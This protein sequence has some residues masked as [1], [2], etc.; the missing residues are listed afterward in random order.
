MRDLETI[1][2]AI[3]ASETGHLVLS[4]LHTTDAMQTVE[5]IINYFPA[6]LHS[7]IRMELSLCL[8]GVICQRLLPRKDLKGRV[9]AIEIMVNTPSV[10]KLLHE[11]KTTELGEQIA[12]GEYYGM[13]TFNQS[14][15]KLIDAG[16]ISYET[17]QEYATSVEELR[18]AHAGLSAGSG[19]VPAM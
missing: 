7:Q 5:R 9:P 15:I 4:T 8:N 6:Y 18:L 11:G 2:T 13:Q 12:H 1:Q 19:N 10:K 16:M 17:A 14:L 3:A